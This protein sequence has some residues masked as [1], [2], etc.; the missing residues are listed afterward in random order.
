MIEKFGIDIVDISKFENTNLLK[1]YN[2]IKI[3]LQSEIDYCLK[4]K[5]P[6]ERFAGKFN[7]KRSN[8]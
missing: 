2:S 1:S 5:N 7:H 6:Y 8:N 3:F 4:F